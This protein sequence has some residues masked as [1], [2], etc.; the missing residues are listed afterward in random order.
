MGPQIGTQ[1]AKGLTI[2]IRDFP[3][4]SPAPSRAPV[5]RDRGCFGTHSNRTVFFAWFI[6]IGFYYSSRFKVLQSIE[7][8]W[9]LSLLQMLIGLP[10]LTVVWI[11]RRKNLPTWLTLDDV[12][13]LIPISICHTLSHLAFLDIDAKTLSTSYFYE[14]IRVFEP[15]W[16]A[17]FARYLLDESYSKRCYMYLAFFVFS[18][19]SAGFY[20]LAYQADLLFCSMVVTFSSSLRYIL[21]L[22]LLRSSKRIGGI[23]NLYFLISIMS[24]GFVCLATIIVDG[25]TNSVEQLLIISLFDSKS[26]QLGSSRII[27]WIGISGVCF[28]LMNYLAFCFLDFAEAVVPHSFAITFLLFLGRRFAI[29]SP[30]LFF[31]PILALPELFASI[32]ASLSVW[33]FLRSLY[34]PAKPRPKRIPVYPTRYS[35]RPRIG[36]LVS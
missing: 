9:A 20:F 36:A 2:S 24:T 4:V 1:R 17:L 25:S 3:A 13:Q 15:F 8:P 14:A 12:L 23:T 5:V 21:A 7:V 11:V 18:L 19:G 26:E 10:L 22:R 34:R 30:F 28:F 31:I 16:T 27:A 6:L 35:T 32:M 29:L 33:L